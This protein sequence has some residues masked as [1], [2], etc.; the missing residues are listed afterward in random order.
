MLISL[1]FAKG[2][3]L[4]CPNCLL[5]VLFSNENQQFNFKTSSKLI[6]PVTNVPLESLSL[7]ID[8]KMNNGNFKQIRMVVEQ[9]FYYK[10]IQIV[11][12]KC[13]ALML[14]RMINYFDVIFVLFRCQSGF[15]LFS[16]PKQIAYIFS[17][18]ILC[19]VSILFVNLSFQLKLK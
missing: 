5:F 11:C 12:I 1:S 17:P 2:V 14:F 9:T 7:L 16:L 3:F 10:Y 6:K 15:L 4:D 8:N 13:T 19:P 18:F